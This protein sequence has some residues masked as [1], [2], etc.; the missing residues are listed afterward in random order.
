MLPLTATGFKPDYYGKLRVANSQEQRFIDSN[1]V[2]ISTHDLNP[3][4]TFTVLRH[5]MDIVDNRELDPA[6]QMI[7]D[8]AVKKI[9][10]AAEVSDW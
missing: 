6:Q 10:K 4:N 5:G 3:D 1:I 2:T 9:T 8:K 7:F